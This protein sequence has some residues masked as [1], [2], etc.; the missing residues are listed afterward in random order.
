VEIDRYLGGKGE[1]PVN[2]DPLVAQLRPTEEEGL[3]GRLRARPP[4]S[5][6]GKRATEFAEV[7][8]SFDPRAAACEAKRCLRCDLEEYAQ[9]KV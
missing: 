6:A 7:I 4:R 8:G 1:L 9:L 2:S 3:E 5:D